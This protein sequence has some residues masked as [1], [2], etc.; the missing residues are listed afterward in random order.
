MTGKEGILRWKRPVRKNKVEK[1][2][3][4]KGAS[5]SP[6]QRGKG[7]PQKIEKHEVCSWVIRWGGEK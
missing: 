4:R 6:G 2:K 5:A 3:D 7:T 1:E